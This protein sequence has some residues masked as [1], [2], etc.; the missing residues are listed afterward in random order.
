MKDAEESD[1]HFYEISHNV[2]E[3]NKSS[4]VHEEKDSFNPDII[5][6]KKEPEITDTKNPEFVVRDVG[7]IHNTNEI[8]IQNQE[9]N[10]ED[11]KHHDMVDS[12]Y[13]MLP[14]ADHMKGVSR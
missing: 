9:N 8:E 2:K 3:L 13:S 11:C 12:E 10:E 1:T 4:V 6:S 5:D 7:D 14:E